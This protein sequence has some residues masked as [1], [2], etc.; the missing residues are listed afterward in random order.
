MLSQ[1]QSHD[2]LSRA[3]A[4]ANA[5]EADAVLI[6][7]DQNISRFANSNLHQ[8]MS[9]ISAGLTLRVIVNGSMGIASTS[10]FDDAELART[11]ELAREAARH[12][13]PLQNFSGLYKENEPVPQLSPMANAHELKV[14]FERGR[15]AGVQFAGSWL[16]C[17]AS[18]ATANSHGVRRFAEMTFSDATVIAL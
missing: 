6:S 11:A 14:M 12:A 7:V 1:E 9:E 18:V 17:A 13:D 2:I 4:A 5:G 10:S 3:L 16:T 8:N 15:E